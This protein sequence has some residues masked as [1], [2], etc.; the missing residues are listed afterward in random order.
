MEDPQTP[1]VDSATPPAPPPSVPPA[2]PHDLKGMKARLTELT[3]QRATFKGQAET[4]SAALEKA[5][6]EHAAALDQLQVKLDDAT[7]STSKHDMERALWQSR[8]DYDADTLD[9]LALKYSNVETPEGGEKPAFGEWFAEFRKS[10]SLFKQ[11][12]APPA[13]PP[14]TPPA[15]STKPPAKPDPTPGHK[16]PPAPAEMTT[17][18]IQALGH[19]EYAAWRNGKK[20]VVR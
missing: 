8:V 9:F 16:P 4:A 17:E 11:P 18:Q 12:G 1:P 13:D 10:S 5:R 14:A 19:E 20:I 3:D 2:D 15:G 6:T 7:A